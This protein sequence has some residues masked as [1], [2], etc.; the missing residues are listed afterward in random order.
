M[1]YE[2]SSCGSDG[3]EVANRVSNR[4]KHNSTDTL[5]PR[6]SNSVAATEVFIELPNEKQ[7]GL[8]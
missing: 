3:Q 1:E 4:I 2:C 8:V 7:S 6:L 5:S